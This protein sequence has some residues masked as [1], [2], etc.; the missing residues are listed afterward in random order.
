LV[1]EVHEAGK[2]LFAWTVNGPATMLQLAEWGVDAIVSDKTELLAKT[3][4]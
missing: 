3:F 2:K 1:R 4:K